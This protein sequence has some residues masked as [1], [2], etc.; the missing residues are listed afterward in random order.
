MQ[1]PSKK[2]IL[3]LETEV[4]GSMPN[5]QR[6]ELMPYYVDT[7]TIDLNKPHGVNFAE[8]GEGKCVKQSF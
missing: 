2:T 8:I 1:D 5:D 7:K 3:P 6:A 4:K